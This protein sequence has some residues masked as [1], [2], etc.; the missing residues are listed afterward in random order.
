M[1]RDREPAPSCRWSIVE[2]AAGNCSRGTPPPK[3]ARDVQVLKHQIVPASAVNRPI[4]GERVDMRAFR[5]IE[6]RIHS[7]IEL[8]PIQP[9]LIVLE[10]VQGG[11]LGQE[12]IRRDQCGNGAGGRGVESPDATWR[13]FDTDPALKGSPAWI[14]GLGPSP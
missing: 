14:S 4:T 2:I 3:T 5:M 13:G 7:E 6:L 9:P 12:V 10:A 1:P 8:I 11:S